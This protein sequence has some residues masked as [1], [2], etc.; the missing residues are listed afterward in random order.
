MTADD[1][2]IVVKGMTPVVREFVASVVKGLEG[3]IATLEARLVASEQRA[4]TP[5][6]VGP[7]GAV[8]ATGE[9]GPEGKPGRDGIDGMNGKDGIG[10][11]GAKGD[12][13]DRGVDGVNGSDGR[14]ADPVEVERMV[15]ETV[16]K[17]V[18]AL[19]VPKDGVGLTGA[20]IDNGG[21]LVVTLSDGA[22]KEVG[23]VVGAVGPVGPQGEPG[24]GIVGPV[25]PDGKPG[26][27]G[28]TFTVDDVI[29][30]ERT[31]DREVTWTLQQNGRTKTFVVKDSPT[32]LYRGTYTEGKT[33]E[34]GDTVTWGGGMWIAKQ[35]T[36]EKPSYSDSE[37]KRVW[38]NCVKAGR[39]GKGLPGPK[40]DPGPKG[41]Q[42]D[43]GPERW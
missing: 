8:G 36:S 41:P 40:G 11:V 15:S 23:Q 28:V 30:I 12:A 19:P 4:M 33:Y 27:D 31:G 24:V 42:G 16:S 21:R 7:A 25:G 10:L 39:D 13:G 14:D 32:A 2:A 6:P 34:A 35:V 29:S 37:A 38:Q 18:S 9:Q 3:Q 26:E 43:R 5:G 22:T 20:L 1:L 17:A